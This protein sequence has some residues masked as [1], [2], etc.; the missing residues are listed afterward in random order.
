LAPQVARRRNE[1]DEAEHHL[2][3]C[4][5]LG[6]MAEAA[7]L[8]RVLLVAQQGDLPDMEGLRSAR[9]GINHAEAVLVLEALARGYANRF[10]HD[11]ALACL[12]TLLDRQP[13][14]PQ[15]WLLRARVQQRLAHGSG[16]GEQAA[17]TD[18]EQAVLL[19]PS[20]EARLGLAGALYRVGRPAD[21][22][23]EYEQ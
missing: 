1:Y 19:S 18:Y 15:A 10:W 2:E 20:F 16:E 23:V 21:A 14:H 5:R 12:N 9:T 17:L 11:D 8:E 22:A 13:Q 6:G 4:E 7:A 3:V